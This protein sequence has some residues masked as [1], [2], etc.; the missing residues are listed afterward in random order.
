MNK[1]L[2]TLIYK[3]LTHNQTHTYLDRLEYLVQTYNTRIHRTVKM[4]PSDAELPQNQAMVLNAHNAHYTKIAGKRKKPKFQVGDHVLVKSLP[5][6]RF[7]RSY[8]KS[9][10]D[11]Q[12]EV[13]EVKTNMPIPMYILRSLDDGELISGGFYSE[14]LQRIRGDVYKVQEVLRERRR[15][16]RR[17]LFV[18]WVGFG[19]EH[20]SWIP[21]ENVERVYEN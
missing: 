8:Q 10:R 15:G 20:N 11:E 19:P 9:F 5:T 6:N 17:E 3:Y 16:G 7:H 12:F 21:A 4:S 13:A 18:S 2:Q 1:T 14:E